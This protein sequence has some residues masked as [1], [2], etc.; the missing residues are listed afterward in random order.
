MKLTQEEIERHT[1][2]QDGIHDSECGEES[3]EEQPKRKKKGSSRKD[4]HAVT[5]PTA[6]QSGPIT[7]TLSFPCLVKSKV[8]K[9]HGRIKPHTK[10]TGSTSAVLCDVKT[11][12][13]FIELA[14]CLHAHLHHSKNLPLDTRRKPEVFDRG[15]R[16]F[17]GLFN[18]CVY[19]G[20]DTVD[21]DTCKIHCHL[22]ILQNMLM[23]GDPMQH[24]AAKGERGLKDWAKHTSKTAQKCGIDTF[25]V[26]TMNRV[27]TQQLMQRAQ[28]GDLWRK[29][30][31][32]ASKE[33]GNSAGAEESPARKVMNRLLPHHRFNTVT[34]VLFSID[35]K[36][37][38]T[39]ATEKTGVVDK[40]MLSKIQQEHGDLVDIDIWGETCLTSS[41]SDGGQLLRGHPVLDRF[42]ELFDWVAVTFENADPDGV[43]G[44]AKI[45]AFYKDGEGVDCAVVHATH[46][47]TRR[48]TRVG[49]TMLIQNS[50]LEFNRR[51]EPALC[52][53][54]ADQIDRGILVFEHVNFKGPL[55]PK[56]NY[57]EDK[58]KHVVSCFEDRDNWAHLFYKWAD[59]LPQAEIRN[60]TPDW[61]GESDTDKESVSSDSSSE[62]DS[63]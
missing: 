56:I 22:H 59:G 47:S 43:M 3:E 20:D 48:E 37:R 34:K 32:Q 10:G 14:L 45:L 54:R 58:S 60:T 50:R 12:V 63:E 5:H 28:Q 46:L 4:K 52:T 31:E 40:R 26:Q 42:G 62:D 19:R 17:L 55:P 57:M 25:L 27:S 44:P 41:T 15:I 1:H 24:D 11:Y 6:N 61:D 7:T 9:K 29:H 18:E 13:E 51:G 36:G 39:I 35:R 33:G 49:N 38:E 53:I 21:S 30:R 2:P 23:F 16:K 8:V